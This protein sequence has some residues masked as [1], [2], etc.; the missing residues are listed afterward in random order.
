MEPMLYYYSNIGQKT[1]CK[2]VTEQFIVDAGNKFEA[3]IIKSLC[4]QQKSGIIGDMKKEYQAT[5]Y[6]SDL[7]HSQ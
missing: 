6:E 7:D 1:Y 3:G 2:D 4:S 5:N